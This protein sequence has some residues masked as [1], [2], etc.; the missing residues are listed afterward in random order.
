MAKKNQDSFRFVLLSNEQESRSADLSGRCVFLRTYENIS[1][2]SFQF[3]F[4]GIS[5]VKEALRIYFRPLLGD[6][7]R[8][9]TI[10]PFFAK[11]EKKS[12][13]GCVFLMF[14][15]AELDDE[16]SA[17][18]ERNEQSIVW[19][20]PMVFA[21]AVEG[22][23][24]VIW[25]DEDM[26]SSLWFDKWVPKFYATAPRDGTD[27]QSVKDAAASFAAS[28][29]R[30]IDR[31]YEADIDSLTPQDIQSMGERTIAAYP[32]Y[33][34]I[35]MSNRG[36]SLL[37]MREKLYTS[38]LR[39]GRVIAASGIVLLI[40]VLAILFQQGSILDAGASSAEEIYFRTFGERSKQPVNSAR[41]KVRSLST[42]DDTDIPLTEI[43]KCLAFA[44]DEMK[45][46]EGI[47]LENLRYGAENTDIVGTSEN[48]EAIQRL[49]SAIESEGFSPRIDN[50][51]RIPNGA[52]RFNMSITRGG[53]Q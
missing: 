22:S 51:Q 3:P 32:A 46:V 18:L 25:S 47:S 44:W 19:P 49:R 5:R 7:S 2:Q 8:D 48:N 33:T 23:G 42:K 13:S 17:V 39:F 1:V 4:S 40:A 15:G 38:L 29:D 24:L 43:V 16:T 14:G 45:D 37:E 53:R 35:D 10:V 41:A 6:A 31:Y 11:T 30:T 26:V 34:T 20:T 21:S 9:V 52:L 28:L 27:I 50:I 12:S 36:S